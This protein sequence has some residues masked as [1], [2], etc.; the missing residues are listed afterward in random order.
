[1][2]PKKNIIIIKYN[3]NNKKIINQ[4]FKI[5]MLKILFLS[6]LIIQSFQFKEDDQKVKVE[7]YFESLCPGCRE[8]INSQIQITLNTKDLLKILDI[9]LVPYGNAK[10][11]SQGNITCQHGENECYGNL[12]ENCVLSKLE[13]PKNIKFVY[14]IEN[15]IEDNQLDFNKTLQDCYIELQIAQQTQGSIQQC[16]TSDE[17]K[18]L[19]IKAGE[20]TDQLSPKHQFVPWI[21]VN[22]IHNDEEQQAAQEDLLIY[23]CSIYKGTIK[24]EACDKR[25]KWFKKYLKNQSSLELCYDK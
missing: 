13:Y 18:Q 24:I 16:L 12:I 11:D 9:E 22:G 15:K 3:N 19:V 14:C 2:I 20:K 5:Q 23:V 17:G 21:I 10:K 6:L 8:F 7:L 1:N 4:L 25:F